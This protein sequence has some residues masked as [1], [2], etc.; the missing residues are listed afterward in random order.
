MQLTI[1]DVSALLD[2]VDVDTAR[3]LEQ[4]LVRVGILVLEALCVSDERFAVHVVEHDHI[5]TGLDRLDSLGEALYLDVDLER[6]AAD[7]PGSLDGA[8]HRAGRPDVVVL[9]HDH[10]AQ[11]VAVHVDASDE[12]AVLLHVPETGCR[13]TR[14]CDDPLV[15]RG[16][17]LL[18]E[19]PRS[20]RDT[21]AARERV[22]RHALAEQNLARGTRHRRYGDLELSIARSGLETLA[23]L[24]MPLDTAVELLKH[25]VEERHTGENALA[26]AEK[27][28][29]LGIFSDDETTP[30]E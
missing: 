24:K 12:H 6:E 7:G 29:A 30:V 27:R 13:L 10:A 8:G 22:E 9:E 15:P 16:A 28:G 11:V 2:V 4:E 21:G 19:E 1:V 23:L 5:S 20:R 14:P 17:R 18:Q 25:L 26:L 3:A